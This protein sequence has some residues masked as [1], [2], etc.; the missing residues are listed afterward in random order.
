[1][2]PAYSPSDWAYECF[3][4]IHLSTGGTEINF[5]KQSAAALA[6]CVPQWNPPF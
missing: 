1:M 4:G 3:M 5:H 6:F 2:K